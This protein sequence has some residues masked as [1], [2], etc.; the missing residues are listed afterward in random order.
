MEFL[1][2]QTVAEE[3]VVSICLQTMGHCGKDRIN[4][5]GGVM[6]NDRDDQRKTIYLFNFTV[7]TVVVASPA[8]CRTA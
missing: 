8:S 1:P 4:N 7:V 2:C 3:L 6:A 5:V